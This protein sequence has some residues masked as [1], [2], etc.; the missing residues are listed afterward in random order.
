MGNA[1]LR[2]NFMRDGRW[3]FMRDGRWRVVFYQPHLRE[4]SIMALILPWFSDAY[5]KR[6][7]RSLHGSAHLL[8]SL[9]LTAIF[10]RKCF[11]TVWGWFDSF[12]KGEYMFMLCRYLFDCQFKALPQNGWA[13]KGWIKI[14]LRTIIDNTL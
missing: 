2:W 8:E 14:N 13:C 1:L 5:L 9:D 12:S 6:Y 10:I 4:T 3:N 11:L 7:S